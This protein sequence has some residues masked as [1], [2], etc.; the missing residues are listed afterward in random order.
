M[1]NVLPLPAYRPASR[2]SFAISLANLDLSHLRCGLLY[3]T[4]VASGRREGC[5]PIRQKFGRDPRSAATVLSPIRVLR[6]YLPCQAPGPGLEQG[7]VTL[8]KWG[9]IGMLRPAQR[10]AGVGGG[11]VTAS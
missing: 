11:C 7:L 4:A 6:G 5:S 10:V 1:G 8:P 3:P 9:P 2:G